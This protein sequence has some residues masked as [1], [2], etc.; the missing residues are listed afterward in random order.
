VTAAGAGRPAGPRH[1]RRWLLPA[2]MLVL[3]V[4]MGAVAVAALK[5][6]SGPLGSPPGSAAG[7]TPTAT[8]RP[9]V[10]I[11]PARP[12]TP[13]ATATVPAACAALAAE[14]RRAAQL[15][16]EAATAARDLDAGRMA[17]IVR[18]M[19]DARDAL[20]SQSSACTDASVPAGSSHPSS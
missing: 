1:A 5:P 12:G 15:L 11:G 20:T 8:S 4:I 19:Q 16:D 9:D 14:A 18:R 7:S 6:D 3:G 17:D 10:P 2:F 13:G